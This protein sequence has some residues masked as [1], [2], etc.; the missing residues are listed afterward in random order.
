MNALHISIEQSKQFS[1][2]IL[3]YVNNADNVKPFYNLRPDISSYQTMM[4]QK[5][6]NPS[7]RP[8]LADELK[9]QYQ[10]AGINI[11]KNHQ[12]NQNIEFLLD[13]DTY[14]VTTGHQLCLFTGP[15]YFIYKILSTIKWCE[16]LK[17]AYPSK[18]FVPVF[19]MATEDHDFEEI[20]H[21]NIGNQKL[22]WDINTHEQPVGR[23]NLET[24]GSF[25]EKVLALAQNDFAKKQVEEWISYYT[26]SENLSI[27]TR[28]LVHHLFNEYGLV[29]LDA[30]SK[31]LKKLLVPYIKKD[32]LE[33]HNYEVLNQTNLKLKQQYKT[34][35]NGRAIN[36][37]YLSKCGRK[38]ITQHKNHFEIQG[39]DIRFT[40]EEITQDIEQNPE[41]YSPNVIMR[42]LYQELILPNLSY[43]G[44]PGEIAYWLQLKD[45]FAHNSIAFPILTLR[46][47]V[48]MVQHQHNNKL[49]KMGL[50]T[51]DLFK[52]S[53]DVERQLVALN[54][55]GGQQEVINSFNHLLQ[56]FIDIAQQ[57]NNKLSSE[58]LSHKLAWGNTLEQLAHKLDKQQREKISAQSLNFFTIQ[59]LYFPKGM[60]QERY[61]NI[62][63][64]GIQQ[65]VKQFIADTY[66]ILN[67]SQTAL[68]IGLKH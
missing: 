63:T 50:S 3:D 18:N 4:E 46:N 8:I 45:V 56:N 40:A 68:T 54:K 10:Q 5:N 9:A 16:E 55:E 44:G 39:T 22:S 62:L 35:V 12:V 48:L 47:F 65:S 60:P 29:I 38:L 13:Q 1:K 27:A 58:I 37:F 51:L 30:D 52:P 67:T 24:F 32:V 43:I 66:G 42:P 34:Q 25:A 14:T 6:Y 49:T 31:S 11:T 15:L 28:K 19:W 7:Y 2:L 59:S 53:I 36:F 61:Y 17:A 23:L 26:Q 64:F 41:N 57:T 33:Q 21:V 20:N